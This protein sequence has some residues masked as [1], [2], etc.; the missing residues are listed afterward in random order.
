MIKVSE[1]SA[2]LD[3]VTSMCTDS[4]PSSVLELPD[5]SAAV[6]TVDHEVLLT[7]W[8]R[9]LGYQ[10]HTIFGHFLF[11]GEGLLCFHWSSLWVSMS[12]GVPQV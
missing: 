8:K 2:A 1:S 4:G 9:G 3:K 6:V 7:G 10:A 11:E 5:L 12:C